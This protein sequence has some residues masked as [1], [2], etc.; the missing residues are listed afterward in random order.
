[1]MGD[2]ATKRKSAFDELGFD[3]SI[4]ALKEEIQALYLEDQI[5]WVV[6]YSGGKDSTATLQT[7]WMAIQDLPA[8]RRHKPVHVIST[9]TLV[10]NPVVSAWVTQ[11][12]RRINNAAE[13]QELP[14]RSHQL[15]PQVQD[16]FW[17]NLIGRGYPVPGVKFRWCT[18]RM[19][20][21]P[22]NRFIADV[23][24]ANGEAIMV[25]GTRKAES[26]KRMHRM[27]K[28]EGRRLRDHLSPNL[29]MPNS[30]VYT[31]VEDWTND[32]VWFF[33][34]QTPNPWGHNNKDLL[35]MYQGAS[36]DGECPLVVDTSTPSCGDSRF[37]CWVCTLVDEDKSMAAMVRHDDEKEWMRPLL[38]F[39]DKLKNADRSTRDFR[40]MSGN[41]QLFHG[42]PIPG[43]YLQKA[44]EDWLRELLEVQTWVQEHGP[45][46]VRD[47]EL[48]SLDELNE[49]R[50]LWVTEKHELEDSLPRIYED[51]VGK[52]FPGKLKRGHSA[53][54]ASEI[55]ILREV[56]GDPLHFEMVR[57]LLATAQGYSTMARRAGLLERLEKAIRKSFYTDEADAKARA[58]K[59]QQLRETLSGQLVL[60]DDLEDAATGKQ[61]PLALEVEAE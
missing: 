42:E 44:R 21:K 9:D 6:G 31:P 15:T 34:M 2:R 10:E 13:E 53:F 29:S 56:A 55:Q 23:V 3:E 48:I 38:Y 18:E 27:T 22:A 19:K 41:V 40:R 61:Q 49:I 59:R 30:L 7:V 32:D 8:E 52:P 47:L 57:E 60:E 5:P 26:S 36:A 54:G 20:I 1:M 33:L 45:D 12:L 37:G 17:V 11:S 58:E 50:R 28:L 14:I 25:L 4:A 43:P 35:V 46:H 39:R 51:A 24:K 16:T